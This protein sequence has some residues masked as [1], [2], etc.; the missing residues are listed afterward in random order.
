MEI[1]STV[2][3]RR[4]PR[5]PRRAIVRPRRFAIVG[6]IAT[7][8]I[9]SVLLVAPVAVATPLYSFRAPFTGAYTPIGHTVSTAGC[10]VSTAKN[11]VA[12]TISVATGKARMGSAASATSC[13]APNSFTGAY[14]SAQVGLL[15]PTFTPAHSGSFR[16]V[17]KWVATWT[18][19]LSATIAN[20]SQYA[21][22]SYSFEAYG[23]VYDSTNKSYSYASN[24]F[25]NGSQVVAKNGSLA[26]T[27]TAHV[28]IFINGT[29]ASG[30]TYYFLAN[31]Y[32][33]AG[34]TVGPG[35]S[36]ASASCNVGTL[37]NGARLV[38]LIVY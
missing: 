1:G 31:L 3:S 35:A 21:G 25:F 28:S 14:A 30:H 8:S 38:A 37:G 11:F 12:P 15:G 19:A 13:K 26:G 27:F 10:G 17:E 33:E 34:I 24:F 36:A 6:A 22:A 4:L 29:L 18:V 20:S 23:S 16:A 7:W 32:E 2:N 9:A 5:P